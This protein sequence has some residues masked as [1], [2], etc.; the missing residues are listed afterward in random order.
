MK[1]NRMMWVLVTLVVLTTLAITF[2]TR[3]SQSQEKTANRSLATSTPYDKGYEDF[4]MYP[5]VDYNAPE[6]TNAVELEERKLKNQ[7]YDNKGFVLT[8]PHPDDG[9]VALDEEAPLPPAIPVAESNLI[10]I[11][12]INDTKAV[13]SNDKSGIYSEYTFQISEVLKRDSSKKVDLGK[14]I[15]IDRAGG[16]VRYP[17]GQKVIYRVSGKNLPRVGSEYVLFLTSDKE[18]LHDKR[19]PNYEILTGYEFRDGKVNPLDTGRH[20]EGFEKTGVANFINNIRN[21]IQTYS[22]Q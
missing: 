17:N 5:V 13:L 19:S 4:S 1:N 22:K 8:N 15:T 21:K 6:T 3:D 12:K 16:S 20:F 7:R 2:G 10:V 14:A 18:S 9:G 11:G